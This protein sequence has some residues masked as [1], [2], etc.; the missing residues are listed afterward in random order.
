[1]LN[2]QSGSIEGE[3]LFQDGDPVTLPIQEPHDVNGV[4]FFGDYV[5]SDVV[6]NE[7]EADAPGFKNGVI[8]Q[9]KLLRE[10]GK[11]ANLLFCFIEKVICVE[12]T[13]PAQMAEDVRLALAGKIPVEEILYPSGIVA[14]YEDITRRVAEKIGR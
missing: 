1:M 4:V 10:R 6:L 12:L 2:R 5:E 8:H 9:G 7:C 3:A 11:F 14:P 13:D